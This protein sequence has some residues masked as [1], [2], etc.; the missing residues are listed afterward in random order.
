MSNT[1]GSMEEL[2]SMVNLGNSG[3]LF[4][5]TLLYFLHDVQIGVY[6]CSKL[7]FYTLPKTLIRFKTIVKLRCLYCKVKNC[8]RKVNKQP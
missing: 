2:M 5:V 7:H 4:I 8:Y 1:E 6:F 3:H